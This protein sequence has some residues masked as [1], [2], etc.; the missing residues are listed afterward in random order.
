MESL[1]AL[2]H[3]AGSVRRIAGETP[4]AVGPSAIGMR[5]NPYGAAPMEN[6]NN[7]RQAM[8]RNDPRQRGLLGAAWALGYFAH[9]ANGGATAITM[10]GG[11]GAFGS[12]Y[13]PQ[14]WPQPWFEDN[15]GLFPVF[16]V[17]RGLS[18]LAGAPL[19]AIDV[20][21]PGKVWGLAAD[22]PEG[23]ELWFANLTPE[24]QRVSL[25][26]NAAT[27]AVL[28]AERFAEAARDAKFLD[29]LEPVNGPIELSAFAVARAR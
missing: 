20:S 25:P 6:P 16:H 26:Q 7:I 9:F 8:N 28:A 13:T 22:T 15:S 4:Y 21:A 12:L 24:P 14:S 1:E 19:R 3:V 29:R 10:G 18:R 17:L 11:V 5:M 23:V 2:P 27:G